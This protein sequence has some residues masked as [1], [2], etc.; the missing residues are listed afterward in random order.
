MIQKTINSTTYIFC[1][2]A[3]VVVDTTLRGFNLSEQHNEQTYEADVA[4]DENARFVSGP[5]FV[6]RGNAS[7]A[8]EEAGDE[9]SS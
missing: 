7:N 3:W 1:L 2:F 6:T 5:Q 8:V 9:I 4:P